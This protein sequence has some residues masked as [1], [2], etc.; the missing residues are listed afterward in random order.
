MEIKYQAIAHIDGACTPVNPNGHMGIGVAVN[1]TNKTGYKFTDAIK[2]G[3]RGYKETSNNIAEYLACKHA[4]EYMIENNL[5]TALIHSDSK[6]VVEQM[7]GRWSIKAGMYKELAL[8]CK[9]LLEHFTFIRFQWIP[10][11]ENQE[12]DDLSKQKLLELGITVKY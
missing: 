9:K 10:R 12:A 4:L 7:S 11:E 3:E 2:F 5:K 6:L 1:V 8:S